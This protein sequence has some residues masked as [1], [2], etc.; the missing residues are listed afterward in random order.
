MVN[1]GIWWEVIM[2]ASYST[3]WQPCL[4]GTQFCL[5]LDENLTGIDNKIWLKWRMVSPSSNLK[6][7]Y[8][9]RHF[10]RGDAS[11]NGGH[12]I[13]LSNDRMAKN[14]F[15]AQKLHEIVTMAPNFFQFLAKSKFFTYLLTWNSSIFFWKRWPTMR[16]PHPLLMQIGNRFF[17]SI[18]PDFNKPSKKGWGSRGHCHL[19]SLKVTS[20][21]HP[22]SWLFLVNDVWPISKFS[23]NRI[24]FIFPQK[25]GSTNMH[26]ATCLHV[27]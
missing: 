2:M 13:T 15:L 24:G 10:G 3:S 16:P 17:S 26:L 23:S 14:Q 18:D 12:P 6:F 25:G 21:I 7:C 9:N 1:N 19:K 22:K 11:R 4:H 5:F 27:G 20:F 8:G